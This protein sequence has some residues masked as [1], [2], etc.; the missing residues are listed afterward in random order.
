MVYKSIGLTYFGGLQFSALCAVG[1]DVAL[2]G[3]QFELNDAWLLINVLSSCPNP[4]F[5]KKNDWSQ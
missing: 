3:L 5:S 1:V 4:E 2:V